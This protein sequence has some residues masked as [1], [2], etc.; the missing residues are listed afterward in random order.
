LSLWEMIIR[1]TYA[2]P[3]RNASEKLGRR[4]DEVE[5]E[6]RTNER[7]RATEAKDPDSSKSSIKLLPLI[8][9]YGDDLRSGVGKGTGTRHRHISWAFLLLP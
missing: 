1:E 7:A 5:G 4:Q 9:A 2:P 3:Q 8:S 6:G